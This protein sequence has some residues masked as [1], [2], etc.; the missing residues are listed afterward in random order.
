MRRLLALAVLALVSLL[1]AAAPAAS[2]GVVTDDPAHPG[3]P[4]YVARPEG[5]GPFPAVVFLHGCGG[6]DGF[7][8]VA[9]D[10]LATH[11]YVA[12]VLDSLGLRH[13]GDACDGGARGQLDEAAAARVVLAWLRRQPDVA[14]DKLGLI[15]FSMGGN[16]V[17][18]LVANGP[19]AAPP[20]L[21]AAVAFYPSCNAHDG[22]KVGVPLAILDGDADKVTPAAPCT[23]LANAAAAA[24]KTVD[25]TVY[26][27]ATHGFN[28]PGPDRTFFGEPMRYDAAATYD[29]AL[30][31]LHFLDAHL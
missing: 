30:K 17:L 16:A 29:S 10:R 5:P 3:V 25:L 19:A 31:T 14:A 12:V 20:G 11:G 18:D 6:V 15:G 2:M 24:G 27:G 21:H 9:A 22:A 13:P 23:A 8:A 4:V 7:D 26:P 28:V 1:P